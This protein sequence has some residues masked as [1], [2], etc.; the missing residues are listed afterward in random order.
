M[1]I[2]AIDILD[3]EAVR[4]YKGD[5]SQKTVYGNPIEI[6]QNFKD[7][8]IEYLHIV[9][10]N[11]AK[12]DGDNY[13]II[14]QIGK[15]IKIQVGGGI[16][17]EETVD[18]YLKVADRVILGTVAVKNPQFFDDM[19]AKYGEEQIV[20]GVD[21]LDG[22]VKV[23]GWLEDSELDYLDFINSLN[24]KYIVCTD[25]SKDGTLTEPNWEMYKKIKNKQIIVSGGVS[26]N[27]HLVHPY[28]AT[29]V[30]KAYYEGKVKIMN[31]KRIIPCLDIKGGKVVKGVNF[32]DIKNIGDPVEI[33]KR[34]EEQ[35]ADEIVLLDITATNENRET[36]FD[37]LKKVA[38]NISIPI[39]IGGGIKTLE[40]IEKAKKYGATNV[41]INSA[42]I[43]NLELIKGNVV[44]IDC[45][46][47]EVYI[48][49]GEKNTGL[50][51]IDWAK[52][53][54]QLGAKEIL[55]TSLKGDGAQT[56]YDIEQT[57][58][59]CDAVNIPVIA[60]G[61]CGSIQDIIDV[62]NQT[63]CDAALVA[64][65]VHYGKA[66]ISDIKAK[67]LMNFGTSQRA[68]MARASE[69]M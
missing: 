24:C 18:K 12:G 66:T 7:M 65:L 47:F 26:K 1:I 17:D 14:K 6:A 52:K 64:S 60:S 29:I 39:T 4:L 32:V 59:V 62:F 57:K 50:D 61:G 68:L 58:A 3:G 2:P 15:M 36:F 51:L 48:N 67:I 25:I 46:D 30:G 9:D 54:E 43:S 37:L 31:K 34:Y 42:A 69:E 41:S 22:K 63:N 40:D 23:N 49:G 27:E 45:K 13:K 10:L 11:G 16:R 53:C 56:G 44:A 20:V 55:L 21:V 38:D 33:A 5:Y 28:Y 8:G 19:I 35:G